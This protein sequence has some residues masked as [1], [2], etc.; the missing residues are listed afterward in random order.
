[1]LSGKVGPSVEVLETTVAFLGG[2]SLITI[3]LDG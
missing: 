1:M 3:P 2:P